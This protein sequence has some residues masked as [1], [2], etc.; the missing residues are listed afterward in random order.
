MTQTSRENKL[1]EKENE[2]F[3]KANEEKNQEIGSLMRQLSE[4]DDYIE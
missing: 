2:F 4:K 3:Q 1:I